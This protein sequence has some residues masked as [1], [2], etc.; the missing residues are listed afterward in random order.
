M[1]NNL[2]LLIAC[3]LFNAISPVVGMHSSVETVFERPEL[4]KNFFDAWFTS[5]LERH[6]MDYE[7][8]SSYTK[9][10]IEAHGKNYPETLCS[11]NCF[12]HC[13]EDLEKRKEKRG[14][15]IAGTLNL[16][17]QF[18]KS[19]SAMHYIIWCQSGCIYSNPLQVIKMEDKD[20]WKHKKIFVRPSVL[21]DMELRTP[22]CLSTYEEFL[23]EKPPWK[24]PVRGRNLK[25][26]VSH[27]DL[28]SYHIDQP[29]DWPKHNAVKNALYCRAYSES[30]IAL[31]RSYYD[32]SGGTMSTRSL[33]Y[34]LQDQKEIG[35]PQVSDD[36]VVAC[37]DT[38]YPVV[39]WSKGIITMQKSVEKESAKKY[40]CPDLLQS[41]PKKIH[42]HT[43]KKDIWFMT[44]SDL[45]CIDYQM[46]EMLKI[47][48]QPV[49]KIFFKNREYDSFLVEDADNDDAIILLYEFRYRTVCKE[50][51]DLVIS[52]LQEVP[53]EKYAI[54][55]KA[56][57][58]MG[59]WQYEQRVGEP[60]MHANMDLSYVKQLG[61]F[62]LVQWNFEMLDKTFAP[63]VYDISSGM[64]I[65]AKGEKNK[66]N[67]NEIMI[68]RTL[69]ANLSIAEW[70]LFKAICACSAH[71][72]N[73]YGRAWWDKQECRD[74]VQ[75]LCNLADRITDPYR[76]EQFKIIIKN[77]IVMPQAILDDAKCTQE[78]PKVRCPQ[79][80]NYIF[81]VGGITFVGGL[82]SLLC[83]YIVGNKSLIRSSFAACSA[84]GL[85]IGGL[86]IKFYIEIDRK[87]D[88]GYKQMHHNDELMKYSENF[89]IILK[90][91]T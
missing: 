6:C 35:I 83:A 70:L 12:H 17:F 39:R 74:P 59:R 52:P 15:E 58:E 69:P 4:Y 89:A 66:K 28:L 3:I 46:E 34:S 16:A 11:E 49:F 37:G 87:L 13:V 64:L 20:A 54:I 33:L 84:G 14:E 56:K 48:I 72:R 23:R 29:T 32:L 21:Q 45:V 19:K 1:N 2:L 51:R 9:S 18:A 57:K 38:G 27:K 78:K 36:F 73:N 63:A 71:S 62:S 68:T 22:S 76:A 10:Q 79:Y 85:I 55:D 26:V 86:L 53:E 67:I 7:Q 60:L 82:I 42:L 77:N 43:N 44:K 80:D 8:L 88:N 47:A 24:L 25:L 40:E 90:K 50:Y 5:Q 41:L 31:H 61:L 30:T 75:Q 65:G 91:C 81:A